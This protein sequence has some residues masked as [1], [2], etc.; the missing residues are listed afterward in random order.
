MP[1][2]HL[3]SLRLP[4]VCFL[5]R[6]PKIHGNRRLAVLFNLLHLSRVHFPRRLEQRKESTMKGFLVGLILG[7]LIVPIALFFYVESGQ[8]PAAASCVD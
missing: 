3:A 7:L 6:S 8:A 2:I 1:S 4:Q 5:F